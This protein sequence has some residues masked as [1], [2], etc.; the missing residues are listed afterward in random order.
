MSSGGVR[1]AMKKNQDETMKQIA[2]NSPAIA[3]LLE[4]LGYGPW[5]IAQAK[6]DKRAKRTNKN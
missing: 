4:D 6:H 2:L 5:R 1:K 3:G